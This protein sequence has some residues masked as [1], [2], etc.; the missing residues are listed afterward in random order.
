V[1]A[2]AAVGLGYVIV[3]NFYPV[4]EY[5]FNILPFIYGG[6]LLAGLLWYGYLRW[7]KPDV[8]ERIGTIQ[9]LSGDEQR[10]LADAGILEVLGGG[11]DRADDGDTDA[12]R[13]KEPVAP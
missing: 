10:R 9:T 8:A 7:T 5:P 4:P 6:I 11:D 2:A 13:E 3:S 12:A 1:S